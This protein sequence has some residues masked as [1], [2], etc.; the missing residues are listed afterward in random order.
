MDSFVSD[1]FHSR[2]VFRG[3]AH[4]AVRVV[5]D[6]FSLPCRFFIVRIHYSLFIPLLM[7]IWPV[8]SGGDH[9]AG[10]YKLLVLDLWSI[11]VV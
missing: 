10:F 2:T 1:F 5:D 8:A 4:S 6:L 9:E 3:S 11:H 7:S